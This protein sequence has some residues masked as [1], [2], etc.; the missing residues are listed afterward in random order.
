MAS[1]FLAILSTGIWQ[2]VMLPLVF[3]GGAYFT[4]KSRGLQFFRFQEML[5][6]VF[7][8]LFKKK[9]APG[10]VTP[11]QALTTALAG[12]VGTG[13]IVGSCQA[14]AMGGYG[15]VFWMVVAAFLGMIIKFFEVTLAIHFRRKNS[16][17]D[18]VGGPMY[19]I[20]YGMKKGRRCLAAL[21]A[22]FAVF[23]SFGMGNLA[24]ANSISSAVVGIV[25]SFSCLTPR[26]ES[27]LS[28]AVGIGVAILLGISILGG[29][30]RIGK[31]SEGVIPGMCLLFLLL[32]LGVL[33]KNAALL[34]ATLSRIV[35][36]AFTAKAI[37]GAGVGIG[38]KLA[39][40]WGLKRSA[41]SN[42]AGLG[43]S[44]IAHA[45]ADTDHPVKQGFFGIFE[46]FADTVVISV[47]TCLAILVC[48]P[49]ETVFSSTTPNATLITAAF[50]TIYGK[51]FAAI[52]IG[53][54]LALFAFSTLLGWSLT[55]K[56]CVE[57]L[58]GERAGKP[59]QFLFILLSVLGAVFPAESIWTLSDL[60]NGLMA[61]PNFIALFSLKN[62]VLDLIKDYFSQKKNLPLPQEKV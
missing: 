50:S 4:V 26:G 7:G 16:Q 11:F 23:A 27:H 47:I 49:D 51:H 6:T 48:L 37:G 52:F 59:Y 30:R 45:A 44:T 13:S 32:A 5:Q 57:F 38:A 39:L 8:S 19:Y 43:S 61:I 62:T 20:L 42:E 2:K 41:F 3:F 14:V 9:S 60:F 36:D 21:F 33:F 40:E 29:I 53:I 56:R 55:G 31:V 17:G 18:F 24:Q 22:V 15:A 35:R 25:N 34:P 58:L 28:L 1:E 46:V 10:S 54:S 12:T